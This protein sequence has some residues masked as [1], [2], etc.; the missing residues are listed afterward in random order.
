MRQG[1][2]KDAIESIP[3]AIYSWACSL[4]L[5]VVCFAS[6]M[7]MGE[8]KCSFA[9]GCL[10]GIVSGPMQTLCMLPQSL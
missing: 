1:T 3:V 2:S 9:S 8:S 6:V 10:L 5:R 4:P 7:P